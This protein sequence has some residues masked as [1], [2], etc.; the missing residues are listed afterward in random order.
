[1]LTRNLPSLFQAPVYWVPTHGFRSL[2]PILIPG[3]L[4]G[5]SP[6]WTS[7]AERRRRDS[8]HGGFRVFPRLGTLVGVGWKGKQ[9]EPSRKNGGGGEGSYFD[10]YPRALFLSYPFHPK[11]ALGPVT[12]PL[13]ADLEHPLIRQRTLLKGKPQ[14]KPKPCLRLTHTITYPFISW[15]SGMESQAL[16]GV[17]GRLRLGLD[18][19]GICLG[20]ACL[21]FFSF[22][23]FHFWRAFLLACLLGTTPD[24]EHLVLSHYS[25]QRNPRLPFR[26]GHSR[27]LRLPTSGEY[28]PDSRV[29]LVGMTY[30]GCGRPISDRAISQRRSWSCCGIATLFPMRLGKSPF[31]GGGRVRWIHAGYQGVSTGAPWKKWFCFWIPFTPAKRWVPLFENSPA[32]ATDKSVDPNC[33][34]GSHVGF[35][36]A[37]SWVFVPVVGFNWSMRLTLSFQAIL[38]CNL[39]LAYLSMLPFPFFAPTGHSRR[40]A[41]MVLVQGIG[42]KMAHFQLAKAIMTQPV[43]GFRPL[44]APIFFEGVGF[45][46]KHLRDAGPFFFPPPWEASFCLW[47]ASF[48]VVPSRGMNISPVSLILGWFSRSKTFQM[49]KGP[50][51]G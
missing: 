34:R 38:S 1:M 37:V 31:H 29:S 49:F 46:L 36:H 28:R 43:D 10:I 16:C 24:P 50:T 30:C 14:G 47:V 35:V 32:W 11:Y 21:H 25:A 26:T 7:T 42:R 45:R 20:L 40:R 15:M 33:V 22:L 13:P 51:S 23:C 5:R 19:V 17:R 2:E 41:H 44:L 48:D 39:S 8:R 6:K 4:S 3:F 18:G 9:R 12:S 27:G